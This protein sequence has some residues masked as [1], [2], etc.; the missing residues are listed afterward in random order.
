VFVW[1]SKDCKFENLNFWILVKSST[2][3][4][5][6]L[7]TITHM[8]LTGCIENFSSVTKR[9]AMCDMRERTEQSREEKNYKFSFFIYIICINVHKYTAAT[10]DC[11]MCMQK[12]SIFNN[13]SRKNGKPC[14][15]VWIWKSGCC[16]FPKTLLHYRGIAHV[17]CRNVI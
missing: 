5:S 1:L 17:A 8:L 12:C 4:P 11:W 16:L 14:G 15:N 2:T 7:S 3:Q 6:K 9:D 10:V 13:I